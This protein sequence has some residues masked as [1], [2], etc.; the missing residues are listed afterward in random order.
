HRKKKSKSPSP[1]SSTSRPRWRRSI[2]WPNGRAAC[3][4]GD[5]SSLPHRAAWLQGPFLARLLTWVSTCGGRSHRWRRRQPGDGLASTRR[6]P[7]PLATAA[8]QIGTDAPCLQS[9]LGIPHRIRIFEA[10]FSFPAIHASHLFDSLAAAK[11]LHRRARAHAGE[12]ITASTNPPPNVRTG[13]RTKLIRKTSRSCF[14]I[15]VF[16]LLSL[17]TSKNLLFFP[18]L[19][20]CYFR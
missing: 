20:I 6:Q 3:W 16:D 15:L 9:Q 11:V 17:I 18:S 19:W 7:F 1:A 12:Q 13:H 4:S 14:P 5:L 10:C 2:A 8:A